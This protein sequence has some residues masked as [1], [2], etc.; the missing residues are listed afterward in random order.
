[1]INNVD[2]YC[3]SYEYQAEVLLWLAQTWAICINEFNEFIIE[4]KH[5]LWAL[6]GLMNPTNELKPET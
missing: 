4:L 2:V 3:M 1:M 5:G 6:G